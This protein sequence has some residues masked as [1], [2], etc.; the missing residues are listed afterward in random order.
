[1]GLPQRRVDETAKRM[2]LPEQTDVDTAAI[3]LRHQ[4]VMLG[5][6]SASPRT[7]LWHFEECRAIEQ[8]KAVVADLI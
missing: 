7:V 5:W 8:L 1:M 6:G 4:V 3:D 2:M